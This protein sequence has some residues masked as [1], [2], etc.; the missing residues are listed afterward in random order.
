MLE[1]V[2]FYEGIWLCSCG[3]PLHLLH[4]LAHLRLSFLIFDKSFVPKMSEFFQVP[5]SLL[6]FS[7]GHCLQLLKALKLLLGPFAFI[8]ASLFLCIFFSNCEG[9]F[10]CGFPC[11]DEIIII[12]FFIS[13]FLMFT[14]YNVNWQLRIS[15]K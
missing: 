1:I 12:W 2:D 8:C 7:L 13:S 15:S 14:K 5:S 6:N 9:F 4:I 10:H 3:C 11:L